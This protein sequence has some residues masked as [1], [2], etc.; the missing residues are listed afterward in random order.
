MIIY[1]GYNA[2]S[3]YRF[4]LPHAGF[5]TSPVN[6]AETC[7]IRLYGK[8]GLP[9]N[10]T[11]GTILATT[12][13]ALT[14]TSATLTSTDKLTA[15]THVW[16]YI[17]Y[18]WTC[19]TP[20]S[21]SSASSIDFSEIKIYESITFAGMGNIPSTDVTFE[22]PQQCA[23]FA[24]RAWYAGIDFNTLSNNIY[25]SQIVEKK[26][27]YSR[28]FQRNDP[29]SERL[30][31]ILP[32]DGGVIRIPEMGQVKRL[33]PY[34]TSLLLFTTNGVWI[35][36]A[37]GGFSA[38][39]FTVRKLSS[40]GTQSSMSVVDVKGIPIWWGEDGILEIK[41]NPQFDS[42]SVDSLT[43]NVIRSFFYGIP[44]PNR[45]FVKG[46][47]DSRK[48][49]VYWLYKSAALTGPSD[50]MYDG[51]LSLN[52]LT[53]AFSPW[54]FKQANININGI[55]YVQ[56]SVGLSIPLVKY[57][58]S[59]RDVSNRL[60]FNYADIKDSKLH[61]DWQNYAT[62][63][64]LDSTLQGTY[65][66]TFTTGYM[67]NG[68]TMKFVQPNYLIVFL[69][70]ETNAGCY[71]QSVFDF[72]ISERSGKWGTKQQIYN[73]TLTD[74]SVNLRRLKLRGKGRSVQFKFTNDGNKPFTIIGWGGFQTV[75]TEL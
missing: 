63:L 58:F 23:F 53:G 51:V 71:V 15:F 61:A 70:Q 75:N 9:A 18:T 42:F 35:I 16:A 2:T 64:A 5:A 60:K 37:T 54:I 57:T 8:N 52:V 68:E 17:T 7:T 65:T 31:D 36:K 10:G 55:S 20:T 72:S 43:D 50:T 32:S 12:S 28:C 41:Y 26:D 27:Q 44:S 66:S 33:F 14:S 67:V 56:D 22:R 49:F 46:V 24:G 69:E 39:D 62:T 40:F 34:Q 4:G 21:N 11:D 13:S 25:F 3:G 30:F 1:P 73:S 45:V 48:S 6:F 29:T 74:R 19:A 47:Y 59:Y 38:T